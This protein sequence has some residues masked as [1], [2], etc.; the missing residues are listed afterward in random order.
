MDSDDKNPIANEGI[1]LK[2]KEKIQKS[3]VKLAE[4]IENAR[5][6]EKKEQLNENPIEFPIFIPKGE[7]KKIRKVDKGKITAAISMFKYE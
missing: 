1:K 5:R 2:N 6:T 7:V 3:S 4:N